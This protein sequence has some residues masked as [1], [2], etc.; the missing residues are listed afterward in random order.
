MEKF[1]TRT[2]A[3]A[4]EPLTNDE[5]LDFL[6]AEDTDEDQIEILIGVARDTVESMTGRALITQTLVYTAN[7]WNDLCDDTRYYMPGASPFRARTIKLDRSPLISITSV[8][9]W[10]AVGSVQLTLDPSAYIVQTGIEP[11]QIVLNSD[12]TWPDLA[13][14]PDA[15]QITFEAGYATADLIPPALKHCVSLLVSNFYDQ[16]APV[17]VGS[18]VAEMPLNIKWLLDQQRVG[19]FHA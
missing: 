17:N 19:G 6:H 18:I 13:D 2:V 3:P 12:E 1:I 14:R 9:Y 16:R 7:K 15:V 10:P 8:D 5:A 11:G 4:S